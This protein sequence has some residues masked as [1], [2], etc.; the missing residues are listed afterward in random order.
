[1]IIVLAIALLALH[2]QLWL[3]DDGYRKTRNLHHAV[4]GQRGLNDRLRER[5]EALEAEVLSLKQSHDAAE[6]RARSDLGLIGS[7][8]TFYQVVPAGTDPP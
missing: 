5:N 2:G 7:S 8:E 3:S 4:A 1:M 6:E